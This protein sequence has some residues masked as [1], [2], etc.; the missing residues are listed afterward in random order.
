M[1]TT[2][3]QTSYDLLPVGEYQAKIGATEVAE[4]KFGPQ[5]KIRFDILTPGFEDRSL[6]GWA[7]ASFSNKSK[8]FAWARAAFG[9]DIPPTYDLDLDHLLG[10]K[11]TLVVVTTRKE[12]G[13]EY[14]NIHDIKAWLPTPAKSLASAPVAPAPPASNEDEI[15]W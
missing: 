12:D 15:P 8:L 10:R 7:S 6:M 1:G 4:G 5:I 2:I 11:V 13:A 3:K 9:K 14:N